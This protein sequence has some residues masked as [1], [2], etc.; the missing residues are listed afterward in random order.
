M[1]FGIER[2]LAKNAANF[3]LSEASLKQ[4]KVT[5]KGTTL[6]ILPASSQLRKQEASR[7]KWPKMT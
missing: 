4:T 6:D 7:G 2:N 5:Y 1:G 3:I